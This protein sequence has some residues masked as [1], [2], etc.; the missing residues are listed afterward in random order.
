MTAQMRELQRIEAQA[1]MTLA[2]LES[3]AHRRLDRAVLFSL[4]A[5]LALFGAWAAVTRM[6]EIA[7][8]PGAVVTD[9]PV[10][11]VQHLEGGLVDAVLVADGDAVREG[12]VL[13]RLSDAQVGA[14]VERLRAREAALRFREAHLRA[15]LDAAP[16]VLV[17]DE[18]G[19]AALAADQVLAHQE[20]LR[21]REERLLVF[22]AAAEQRRA[23]QL[24][25]AAQREGIRR[26]LALQQGELALREQLL[27][28][29]LTTRIAVLETRRAVLAAAAEAERLEAMEEASSRARAEAEA[30]LAETERAL[31]DEAARDLGRVVD[32]R[33]EVAEGLRE[34]LERAGRRVVLAPAAGIVKGLQVRHAGAV[35]APG[36]ALMEI[37]PAEARLLVEARLSP[38][39]VGFVAA[40]QRVRVR[41]E[42][43]DH[44]RFGT[45]E[46]TVVHV[47]PG[48]TLDAENRPYYALRVALAEQHV[49]HDATLHR[50]LPGMTVQGD[51]VTGGKSLL[52]YLIKPVHA[53]MNEGFR[54]R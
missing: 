54:E 49:G 15:F 28:Q 13:L 48:T 36:S 30:R 46:G 32:E 40:G 29:G 45:V 52:A 20:R 18:P 7:V 53:A 3:P 34:A 2:G 43:F 1:L 38:R 33:L 47:A 11:T 37:V 12:Q 22:A 42:A 41:V 5:L 6:P 21:L 19:F 35:V 27:A 24:A 39:D 9:E 4:L 50:L 44:A 23:E 14:E 25:L 8:A 10:V 51:V 16:L 17:A 31:R 26:Q